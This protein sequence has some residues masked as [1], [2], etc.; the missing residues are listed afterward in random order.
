[1][2]RLY[3]H[4]CHGNTKQCV[5]GESKEISNSWALVDKLWN[6]D[7]S[8]GTKN[9]IIKFNDVG[10]KSQNT[11]WGESEVQPSPFVQQKFQRNERHELRPTKDASSE[12]GCWTGS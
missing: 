10:K 5:K 1:M 9:I 8:C 6:H 4:G 11:K 7:I 2:Q 12:G 3:L